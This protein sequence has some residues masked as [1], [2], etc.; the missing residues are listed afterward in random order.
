MMEY[1]KV[2]SAP[3][4]HLG[5]QV[6]GDSSISL[7]YFQKLTDFLLMKAAKEKLDNYRVFNDFVQEGRCVT[8]LT[9]HW[10]VLV[11]L[12]WQ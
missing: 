2:D 1:G 11:T 6:E 7:L 4:S 9:F 3:H 8:L 12:S 5:I 10:P